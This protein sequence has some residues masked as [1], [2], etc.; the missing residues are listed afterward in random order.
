MFYL[1]VD[2][3]GT[4]IAVGVVDEEMKIVAKASNK[5]PAPGNPEALCDVIKTTCD[6][7]LK[8]AGLAYSDIKALGMGCPGA[9][10][11]DDGIV[12]FANNLDFHNVPLRKMVEE[13]IPGIPVSMAN[14]A[15]AAAYG[16][17]K[18]G[19]LKGAKHSLAITLGTGV[20]GGIIID[21]KIYC[22]F[23]YAG[24]ELGHTVIVTDG[25]PC[26]CGRKG[27]WEAYASATGLIRLTLEAM[28]KHPESLLHTLAAENEVEGRTAFLAAERGDETALAVCTDYARYLASGLVSMINVLH[29]EAVALG[30]GVAAAPDELLL[31]PVRE[32]VA[33][34]CYARHTNQVPHILRAEMGNDAGIIGAALLGRAI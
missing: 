15:N 6:E 4:N 29:P 18:A 32:I 19:A 13:R 30:G 23:N 14:D 20:G 10:N 27:C 7:A 11:D 24:G 2:I 31:N 8:N 34:E 1:G 16:E 17:Y 9:I 25:R 3:G 21:G 5:T 12:E 26:S 22:G 33:R 28:E